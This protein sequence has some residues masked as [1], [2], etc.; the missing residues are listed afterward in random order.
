MWIE[1]I[2]SYGTYKQEINK[3]T[4]FKVSV[5]YLKRN[6]NGNKTDS[7]IHPERHFLSSKCSAIT[8][9]SL[10]PVP[11]WPLRSSFIA[12]ARRSWVWILYFEGFRKRHQYHL[13]PRHT[14]NQNTQKKTQ[15]HTLFVVGVVLLP[16]TFIILILFFFLVILAL[17]GS[18][19]NNF[20]KNYC[21]LWHFV[22]VSSSSKRQLNSNSLR[23][24]GVRYNGFRENMHSPLRHNKAEG[25]ALRGRRSPRVL[26][27]REYYSRPFHNARCCEASLGF[28][29]RQRHANDLQRKTGVFNLWNLCWDVCFAFSFLVGWCS[30][31]W[32]VDFHRNVVMFV[33]M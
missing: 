18:R 23:S 12:C 3:T 2:Y 24:V 8:T 5:Q 15:P 10:A 32:I 16:L 9:M 20:L 11:T 1:K 6:N 22:C 21:F 30:A 13:R 14:T 25:S 4:T 27:R 33:I 28:Q 7:W 17:N 31:L 19:E 29:Q 26:S